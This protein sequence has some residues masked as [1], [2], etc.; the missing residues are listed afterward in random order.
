MRE[1]RVEVER[2]PG[3]APTLRFPA[4][5]NAAAELLDRQ[6]ELG[7]G[8]HPAYVDAER[9][10]SYAGLAERAARVGN[11]LLGLG[12]QPEQRVALLLL[13]TVDF[14]CVFLGA[15]R[16]GLVPIPLNTLMTAEDYA[17]MLGDSRAR[18]VVV[19]APLREKVAA[20]LAQL[21]A[22]PGHPPP[23]RLIVAGG[24]ADELEA[25]L[26]P[27]APA[28]T[29]AATSPDEVAFWLYSSGST[30]SPKGT[31]HLHRNL[32]T[33]AVLYSQ[34]VLGFGPDDVVHSAAKLFFAYGLGNAL[35]F[36]LSVGATAV[37]QPGRPTPAAIREVMQAHQPTVFCGVPTLFA[38]LL[39]DEEFSEGVSPRLR[40][41]T[42]AGEGLPA[43]LG[44]T[45]RERFGAPILDGIGSTEQL[46]IFISNRPD[47]IRD[48]A[49]GK[50]V[51]GYE[52]E[53]RDEAGAPVAGEE[54]GVLWVRSPS[55]ACGYWN[56]RAK[57]LATFHGPWSCTG[58]R[59]RRDAEG[60]YVYDGRADDMLKVSGIW[61]SPFEVE[62]TL[63]EHEGVR[64]AAVVGHETED[65]L[66]KPK[67]FVVLAAGRSPGEE[68]T[69]EL[70]AFVKER[71][72]PYK[73]PRWIEFVDALPKT[74]TGKIQRFK[75]R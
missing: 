66:L 29:P 1:H 20:A 60:Y 18:A 11:A 47:D 3:E 68:L 55:A 31:Q 44:K 65:G 64:E 40:V 49:S 67:A 5:Y 34:E 24:E 58:D 43:H 62:S 73:Y 61:V 17:Y 71:L 33:T 75:L 25:L 2:T 19:S 41:C 42:S 35:T 10:L 22:G 36:P 70:Q 37:L 46:H 59:Y 51:P 27:A 26:S 4:V 45:W 21:P 8:E 16:A 30:G 72:A 54:S 63:S 69:R 52:V 50:P 74:A 48:G 12:L 15:M 28:L 57:T 14:P 23:P 39:A 13:D 38:S 6:L 9:T 56:L 7:R 32:P 53:L